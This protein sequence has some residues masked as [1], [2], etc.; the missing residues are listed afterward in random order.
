MAGITVCDVC[1]GEYRTEEVRREGMTFFEGKC[2]NCETFHIV[3][4]FIVG[5]PVEVRPLRSN[6]YVYRS[7]DNGPDELL[8]VTLHKWVAED[9]SNTHFSSYIQERME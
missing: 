1:G 4:A 9:W 7:Q 6:Y 2:P 5:E 3:P 8:F